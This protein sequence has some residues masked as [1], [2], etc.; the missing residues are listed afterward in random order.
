ML[1]FQLSDRILVEE[2]VV[3]CTVCYQ[4]RVVCVTYYLYWIVPHPSSQADSL[5]FYQ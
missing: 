4:N 1:G 2:F 3:L 5:L